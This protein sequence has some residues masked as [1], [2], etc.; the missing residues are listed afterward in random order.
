MRRP[1]LA[2]G[3]FA[4]IAS[5]TVLALPSKAQ[6]SGAIFTTNSTGS[7]VNGNIYSDKTQV[8][9]NGGPGLGA[10]AGAASLPDG[11]YVFMV[12]DPP[13]KTLLSTDIAACR[14][15]QISGGLMI[16]IVTTDPTCPAPHVTGTDS[17]E[18]G[19]NV[20]LM[21]YLDTPNNGGEYK[22]WATPVGDYQ[23]DL[24]VV[25]CNMATHGFIPSDSKTDNF[26]VKVPSIVEIDT[27]FWI[28]GTSTLLNGMGITWTDTTGV[29]NRKWSYTNLAI[30]LDHQAH[31]EEP[32]A[33][34]HYIQLYNQPGCNVAGVFIQGELLKNQGPQTIAVK[35]RPNESNFSFLIGVACQ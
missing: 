1:I 4:F 32:E 35:I 15:F 7:E 9:L 10:P 17:D 27:K 11:V 33:G 30:Q 16:A 18:G 24:S 34:T 28:G 14:R 8:Y 19:I 26:K 2:L 31:V 3:L 21:P 6:L 22:A 25:D 5:V 23:C 29:S 13:G 12:T 20:Q